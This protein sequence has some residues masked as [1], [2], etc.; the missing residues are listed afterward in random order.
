MAIASGQCKL[1]R[2]D[3]AFPKHVW[4]KDGAGT[5]WHGMCVNRAAGEYKGWPMEEDQ[6]REIFG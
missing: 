6:W 5:L 2:G 1:V 4:Y 3:G